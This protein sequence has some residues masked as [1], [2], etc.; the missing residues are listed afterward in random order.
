[1]FRT[2]LTV[3][4]TVF[5]ITAETYIPERCLPL[6][7]GVTHFVDLIDIQ[8]GDASVN[9]RIYLEG[10]FHPHAGVFYFTDK[11]RNNLVEPFNQAFGNSAAM[12]RLVEK[13]VAINIAAELVNT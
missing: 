13:V 4:V 10:T 8:R 9:Q 1:M 5:S 6:T 3:S 2:N 11:S 7:E 12:L